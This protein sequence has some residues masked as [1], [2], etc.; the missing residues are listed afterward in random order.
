MPGWRYGAEAGSQQGPAH[1]GA[2]SVQEHLNS[3]TRPGLIIHYNL[4]AVG[5]VVCKELAG[6]P[7]RPVRHQVQV[8]GQH[9]SPQHTAAEGG[10]PLVV[11]LLQPVEAPV[12]ALCIA[13][14]VLSAPLV[15]PLELA[16][17]KNELVKRNTLVLFPPGGM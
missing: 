4:P 14:L 1:R 17:R 12:T 9:S 13:T 16:C 3:K 15:E 2:T 6:Q 10:L 8:A 5:V 11:P 7:V